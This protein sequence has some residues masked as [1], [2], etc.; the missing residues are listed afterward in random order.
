MSKQQRDVSRR[1]RV[2]EMQKQTAAKERNRRLLIGLAIVVV[3][4]AVV[5]AFVVFSG[6]GSSTKTPAATPPAT[7]S[8]QALVVGSNA[9]AKY[10]VVVYEDFLCPYCRQFETSSRDFL[11]AAAA[12]GTVQVEYRP[13]HLL[14]DDY[15][16]RALTAWAA[17]LE[18]GTPKQALRLHDLLYDNQPYEQTANKPG[19]SK[20][21]GWAKQAG[22]SSSN[23]LDAMGKSD[24]TYVDAAD[25]AATKA[26]VTGT[27]TV[28]VNGQ[29][30]S[31]SSISSMVDN[32]ER[33]ISSS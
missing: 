18:G 5:A 30:L 14:S 32:L 31:G 21:Q 7:A 12:K 27:P 6:G 33:E 28:F 2:A 22:V 3:L 1:E 13:F 23:V 11:R 25:A 26:G 8:S 20:L 16:T 24:P 9:K 19:T 15:S 10:K 29:E 4:S 17:V